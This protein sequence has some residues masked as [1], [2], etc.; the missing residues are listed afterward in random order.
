MYRLK[1]LTRLDFRKEV[2]LL[3]TILS[4]Y[5][6]FDDSY[7]LPFKPRHKK[8]MIVKP[9]EHFRNRDLTENQ[10]N[11]FRQELLKGKLGVMY[12]TLATVQFYQA[13][14]ISEVAGIHDE[15]I[16]LNEKKELSRLKISK[17]VMYD[18]KKKGVIQNS[19][20][21]SKSNAGSKESPLFPEGYYAFQRYF[22]T[23]GERKGALFTQQNGELLTFRQIQHAYD[24]AFKLA[25]L[26]FS[27]THILRHGGARLAYD[28][29]HG[30]FGVAKQILGNTD[31]KSIQVYANRSTSALNEHSERIWKK[32]LEEISSTAPQNSTTNEE[33]K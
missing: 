30:D 6:E 33:S 17:S 12:F 13:L 2:A 21:N 7:Q 10:F 31:V 16:H 4:Y 26:N 22:A 25:G 15:D 5:S 8:D 19:F 20:K 3:K 14:R 1:E 9:K 18:S 28:S 27:G 23:Y 29:S 11:R 32:H 24:R